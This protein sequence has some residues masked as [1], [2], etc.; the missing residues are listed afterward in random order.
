MLK[1][2]SRLACPG[3]RVSL[4]LADGALVCRECHEHYPI[5]NG[6]PILLTG[7]SRQ[8]LAEL[9][10]RP[11]AAEMIADHESGGRK[12]RVSTLLHITP[13]WRRYYQVSADDFVLSVGGARRP[14]R[15]RR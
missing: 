7:Q 5:E 13:D 6:V 1:Y 8:E 9:L 10:E 15:P 12:Q 4:S 2:L 14:Y 3:C 11:E